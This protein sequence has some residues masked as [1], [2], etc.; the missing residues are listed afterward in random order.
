MTDGIS[1]GLLS[2]NSSLVVVL[3][4]LGFA[5]A[6]WVYRANPRE[7]ENQGFAL[8]VLFIVSWVACY[9][10]AQLG[11]PTL[12]FRLT[13]FAVSMFFV[14]YHF[15]IVRWVLCMRGRP[16]RILGVVVLVYGMV[17][18]GLALGSDIIISRSVSV[19]S[20]VSPVFGDAKWA[21]S[22]TAVP[23]SF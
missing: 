3:S 6:V 12:W 10:L 4:A 18:A 7:R 16:Y 5:M 11:D 17:M 20:T 19:G 22:F 14:T 1:R 23:G 21:F 8:M 13:A 15:F 2:L 9:H